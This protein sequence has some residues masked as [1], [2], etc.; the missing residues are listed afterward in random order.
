MPVITTKKIQLDIKNFMT[1]MIWLKEE[2]KN[3]Y[4]TY[5]DTD[6]STLVPALVSGVSGA[7]VDSHLTKDEFI[8]GITFVEDLGDFFSNSSVSQTDYMQTCNRLKYGSASISTQLSNATE[9]LGTR[10]QTLGVNCIG[11]FEDARNIL[12]FYINNELGDMIAS[13]DAQRIVAG[14]D[15]TVSDLSAGI[16]LV[17]QYKKMINNEVV[18]Q[19]LYEATVAIWQRF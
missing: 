4:D 18:T 15:M 5:W 9:G 16:T 12:N 1:G 8:N 11:Y 19:A 2:S 7:T 13:L 3:I 6:A 10:L 17:E 14:S